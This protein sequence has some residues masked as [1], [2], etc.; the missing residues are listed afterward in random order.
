[1]DD[2]ITTERQDAIAIATLNRPERLNAL[3]QDLVRAVP[4]TLTAL[5]SDPG[6]RAVVLTGAGRGF[7]S[8]LDL[9]ASK[10]LD[11]ATPRPPRVKYESQQRFAAMVRAI[12]GLPVPVIAAINGPAAGSG[13]AIALASDV[14]VVDPAA[15]FHPAALKIGLSAG[16]C[17]LS[18]LLPRLIGSARAFEVLLTGRPILAEEAVRI[19]LA[20]EPRDGIRALDTA[21][22]IAS[23]I[24]QYDAFAVKMT[25]EVLWSN[26]DN[27]FDAAIELENRTQI[28]LGLADPRRGDRDAV[29]RKGR[30]R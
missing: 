28:L 27:S 2:L 1:M 29:L 6:C 11:G 8:G 30:P 15:A 24:A 19:G 17:G 7:C 22:A 10:D 14:R 23:E 4:A 3:T 21:V 26:L 18:Y 13:M 20:I 25:R 9:R 5:A 12:R 16:E